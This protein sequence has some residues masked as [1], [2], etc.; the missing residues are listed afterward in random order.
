MGTSVGLEIVVV[1]SGGKCWATGDG[2][3][4]E[5]EDGSM[6]WIKFVIES[7]GSKR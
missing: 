2:K 6:I 3:R 4:A 5:Q 7:Y 1:G